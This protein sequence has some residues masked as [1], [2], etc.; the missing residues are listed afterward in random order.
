MLSQRSEWRAWNGEGITYA[1]GAKAVILLWEAMRIKRG[2]GISFII[3]EQGGTQKLEDLILEPLIS[4]INTRAS[5]KIVKLR[6]QD[7]ASF[8]VRSP[9]H[10]GDNYS[11]PGT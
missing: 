7:E 5:R 3:T 9:K 2:R 10:K 6:E 1:L 8:F 11:T 4:Y